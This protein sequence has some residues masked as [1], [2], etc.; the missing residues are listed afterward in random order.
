MDSDIPVSKYGR[1]L[2]EAS[3]R[4]FLSVVEVFLKVGADINS[5]AFDVIG[6]TPL[7]SGDLGW[8]KEVFELLL[9]NGANVS[10]Q[11]FWGRTPV[12]CAAFGRINKELESAVTRRESRKIPLHAKCDGRSLRSSLAT[13]HVSWFPIT[14]SQIDRDKELRQ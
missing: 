4:G 2:C 7:C 3:V 10:A 11:D 5:D 6:T 14:L 12:C 8:H 9:R 1:A 13:D